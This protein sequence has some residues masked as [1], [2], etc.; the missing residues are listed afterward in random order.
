[1]C[2][3]VQPVPRRLPGYMPVYLD[4]D[5]TYRTEKDMV[6][7]VGSTA[8][9]RSREWLNELPFG[10]TPEDC[11]PRTRSARTHV[12][13]VSL[14]E[15]ARCE[16][17]RDHFNYHA[18]ELNIERILSLDEAASL[19]VTSRWLSAEGVWDADT[20]RVFLWAYFHNHPDVVS[21]LAERADMDAFCRL[22]FDVDCAATAGEH[23]DL[24]ALTSRLRAVSTHSGAV[25][26][27]ALSRAFLKA[28]RKEHLE[29][30]KS[31]VRTSDVDCG[32]EGNE[33]LIWAYRTGNVPMAIF[34]LEQP[35]VDPGACMSYAAKNASTPR[36]EDSKDVLEKVAAAY[37]HHSMADVRRTCAKINQ[38][39]LASH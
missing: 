29:F 36:S 19:D 2:A 26:R 38:R 1:M 14:P 21:K 7:H 9:D 15:H 13:V 22:C 35:T 27:R 25:V 18:S 34:L 10:V 33:A 37:G 39:D 12:A 8:K 23:D 28:S 31:L 4:A 6:L 16:R 32:T 3:Q 17:F 5:G 30:V 20:T 24:D 11:L